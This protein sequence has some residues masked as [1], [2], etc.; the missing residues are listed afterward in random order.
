MYGIK[1]FIFQEKEEK[2]EKNPITPNL[3]AKDYDEVHEAFKEIGFT[4][5]MFILIP[6]KEVK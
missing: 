3:F 6:S 4:H 2:I 1:G 5:Y